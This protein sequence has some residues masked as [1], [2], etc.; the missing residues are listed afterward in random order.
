MLKLP[1]RFVIPLPIRHLELL[2]FTDQEWRLL[3]DGG[4]E[5]FDLPPERVREALSVRGQHPRLSANDCFCLVSTRCYEKGILLTGDGLLR[6]VA[7]EAGVR[8]HGVLWMVDELKAANACDDDLL[9]SAL[10]IWRDD[11]AVFLPAAE[12]ERRLRRLRRP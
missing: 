8:V 4:I 5:T 9:I 7:A 10:E 3:V 1:Y 2:D 6:R 11:Q 12:I